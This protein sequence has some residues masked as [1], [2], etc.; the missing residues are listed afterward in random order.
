MPAGQGRLTGQET[1]MPRLALARAAGGVPAASPRCR[2]AVAASLSALTLLVMAGC[3]S[4]AS[5]PGPATASPSPPAGQTYASKAFVVPL[6][7]TVGTS[8]KSPPNPDSRNLLAWDAADGSSGKVRFLVPVN[9]YRPGSVFPEAPP[10]DYLTYL[11]GLTSQGII[12]LSDVTKTTVDG[13]PA[14]LMTETP[15]ADHG[16]DGAFGC[17]TTGA[18]QTE[19]CYGPQP[20]W[21]T[22]IAVIPVGNS[23]LFA[24]ARTSKASPNE[25][26]LTTFETMLN[27]VR[28]R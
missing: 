16:F 19:G 28:F 6:T 24:W 14:T 2:L 20:E 12:K 15:A 27:S 1:A 23:T 8:L 4:A 22:R 9:L 3:S 26:F 10:K 18:D 5:T 13:H 21:I 11:H 25:A 7:V 17:P